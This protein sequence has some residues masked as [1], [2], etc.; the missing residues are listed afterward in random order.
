MACLDDL[1]ITN[2]VGNALLEPARGSA[3]AHL[4]ECA[5]CY[6]LVAAI[7]SPRGAREAARLAPG[8]AVGRYV[9]ERIAGAGAMGVV[10]AAKDPGLDRMVA[11]KCVA[12][13]GDPRARER[14]LREAQAM[15]QLSHRN[16]VT[17]FDVGEHDRD[18]FFAMELV[19]GRTLR[20]WLGEPPTA[21]EVVRVIADAGRGLAAAHAA[22]IVHRD[23]KP[24]NVLIAGDGRVCVTDFGLARA[25]GTLAALAETPVV[26]LTVTGQIIGTPV[27]MAPELLAGGA[28]TPA[29]DQ[30]SFCVVA[31]E[32]L[33]GARPFAGKT[34][35]ELRD[36][37]A[38]GPPL[39]TRLPA[40]LRRVLARGLDPDPAQRFASLDACV[41]ALVADPAAR[42]RR[43]GLG[44]GGIVA[45]ALL[46]ALCMRRE[47]SCPDPRGRLAGAWDEA[48]RGQVVRAFLPHPQPYVATALGHA[49]GALDRYADRWV[50]L[51]RD[52]CHATYIRHDQTEARYA[53]E[54]ACF[55]RRRG[56][57]AA[58]ATLF[59][60]APDGET[61]RHAA[62]IVDGLPDLAPCSNGEVLADQP[63]LPA[64]PIARAHVLAALQTLA[65][66]QA[67]AR[68]GKYVAAQQLVTPLIAQARSLGYAPAL[69]EAL[70]LDGKLKQA[71]TRDGHAAEVA[72]N[73]AASIA[74]TSKD[75]A[76]AARVWLHLVYTLAALEQ[77]FAEA[78]AVL[79]AA[80]T[81]V[82]RAGDPPGL[83]IDWHTT[84]GMVLLEQG[85]AEEATAHFRDALKLAETTAPTRIS[86]QLGKLAT[87]LDASGHYDEAHAVALRAVELTAK[88]LGPDHPDLAFTL[89]A[90]GAID[91]DAGRYADAR[92]DY[93]R[94]FAILDRLGEP[95]YNVT[96]AI[97]GLGNAAQALGLLDEARA[98]HEQVLKI[99]ETQTPNSPHVGDALINLGMD[100]VA[101]GHVDEA[102]ASYDRAL[103]IYRAA[104]GADH[105]TVALALR[106]RAQLEMGTDAAIADLV[107]ALRISVPALGGEHAQIGVL[108]G[109][110]ANAYAAQHRWREAAAEYDLAIAIQDKALGPDHPMTGLALVGLAQVYI[111]QHELQRASAALSRALAIDAKSNDR[112][113]MG[114]A[115]FLL[116]RVAMATHEDTKAVQAAAAAYRELADSKDPA[117]VHVRDVI[118]AL[119]PQAAK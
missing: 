87:V 113:A 14:M 62:A 31:W 61:I 64:Q 76:L 3:L 85:K 69:G 33:A 42:G 95:T 98:R 43:L 109:N 119:W 6:E 105:P 101:Q 2:L 53:A 28:A 37:I 41:A 27:Y 80:R 96:E 26:D 16:V 22:G 50:D 115:H 17:V 7:G 67:L 57:L 12:G 1:T 48:R 39:D 63:A 9:V 8:T 45:T 84:S 100:L 112:H 81:A 47:A 54:L 55:E 49:T 34:L 114:L 118:S 91:Y 77:R 23:F 83:V 51:R 117:H 88:E 70:Y 10:Y 5:T 66:A 72:L 108:H 65:S 13:P 21:A 52:A 60:D 56:D 92:A 75:D 20:D 93:L 71:T 110:L 90:L 18:V 44:A 82:Q 68:T 58:V 38:T 111:E 35:A 19:E 40:R 103:Q 86:D 78:S 106:Q 79:P 15:A 4:D 89:D 102:R 99:R 46:V 116:A 30:F 59:A 97:E 74:A 24:E 11:L 25:E 32:A 104:Y 73:E 107:E 29:S 94:A 36:A